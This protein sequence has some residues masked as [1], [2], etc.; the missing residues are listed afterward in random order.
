MKKTL[1]HLRNGMAVSAFLALI[2]SPLFQYFILI[3]GVLAV[4][5]LLA[6]IFF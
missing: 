5:F 6:T 4:A 3:F 2:V 1:V